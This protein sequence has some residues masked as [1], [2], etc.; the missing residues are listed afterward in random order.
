MKGKAGRPWSEKS[1]HS[2]L[3]IRLSNETHDRLVAYAAEHNMTMTAV[4]TMAL[5]K[6]LSETK[7][8]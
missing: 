1:K 3:T 8:N 5:E 7:D 2:T 4:A 6:E